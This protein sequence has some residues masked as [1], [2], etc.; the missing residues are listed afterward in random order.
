[1]E[2]LQVAKFK[3]NGRMCGYKLIPE[4]IVFAQFKRVTLKGDGGPGIF[5]E[6]LE[7]FRVTDL[8]FGN[9]ELESDV[10][11]YVRVTHAI[12]NKGEE[13]TRPE[14]LNV[15]VRHFSQLIQDEINWP[16]SRFSTNVV[17]WDNPLDRVSR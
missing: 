8:V 17:S 12:E 5:G 11:S 6:D 7:V 15:A 1:M 4:I 16:N 10:V 9:Q 2:Q 14:A 13:L 3:I